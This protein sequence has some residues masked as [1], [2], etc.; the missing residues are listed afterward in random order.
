MRNEH[1]IRKKKGNRAL[2]GLAVVI[3]VATT[4]VFQIDIMKK[5][6]PDPEA[7]A[8]MPRSSIAHPIIN[9]DGNTALAGFTNNTGGNGSSW[10][11]AVVIEDLEITAG[12]DEHCI[13]ISNTDLYL[14][15][16][17][18]TLSGATSND[19]AGIYLD[20]CTNVNVTGNE[21]TGNYHG[22]YLYFSNNNTI[23]GN[24]ATGNTGAGII[25]SL[26]N[27]NTISGNNAT[28][29]PGSGIVLSFSHENTISGNNA[30]GNS[31][32]GIFLYW[33]NNNTIS[34]SHAMENGN[35]GIFLV[36]S[37]NNTISGN[38]VTGNDNDAIS[39]YTDCLDNTVSLN[40]IE[41]TCVNFDFS[42]HWTHNYW[43]DYES[44][45]P[46]ATNNGFY[47]DTPYEFDTVFQDDFP[48]VIPTLP[49]SNP[50]AEIMTNVT[51]ILEGDRVQ[52]GF[53]GNPGNGITSYQWD[54]DDGSSN[55]TS[56]SPVH[57]YTAA[58][59]YTVTLTITD[60]DGDT[61][62]TSITIQ[63]TGETGGLD[64]S[65]IIIIVIGTVL[66]VSI[67]GNAL[68]FLKVRNLKGTSP[69]KGA[70]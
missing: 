60:I 26:A 28:G 7:G 24:K 47:W 64:A 34:G 30:T 38:H 5:G 45:Y 61:S 50:R 58:G 4:L 14:V 13:N 1:L 68:L 66:G 10:E 17:D 41:G 35:N 33:S 9:L 53:I 69:R 15:I 62:S 54:F 16:R 6:E 63:V 59:D 36:S 32:D 29:N 21:V 52:F 18:C 42:D 48:L 22:V 8:A 70:K 44:K 2:I 51:S 40:M 20:N 37:N 23:S 12:T 46:D 19:R 55:S 31:N 67:L 3:V 57:R 25:L 39:I 56:A 49:D 65:T 43:Y 11:Q 27:N